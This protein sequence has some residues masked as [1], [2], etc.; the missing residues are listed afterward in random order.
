MVDCGKCFHNGVCEFA[1][2]SDAV[3]CAACLGFETGEH[4][5]NC[6]YHEPCEVRNRV[7]CRKL[8]RYM[9]E[10]GFC[11]EGVKGDD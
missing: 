8:C 5:Q 3:N 1:Y 11:S 2:D 10:D 7:W 9:K 6:Q 4:C